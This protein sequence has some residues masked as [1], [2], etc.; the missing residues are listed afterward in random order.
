M[1]A[2][3]EFRLLDVLFPGLFFVLLLRLF[4]SRFFFVYLMN[5]LKLIAHALSLS[6]FD[7][8]C[9]VFAVVTFR[10]LVCAFSTKLF[11][12]AKKLRK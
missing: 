12:F 1:A 2:Q 8:F 6:F 4:L 11:E 3:E 10:Y 7:L 9:F 5:V